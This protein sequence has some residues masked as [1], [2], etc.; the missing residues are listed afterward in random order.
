MRL[1]QGLIERRR[2]LRNLFFHLISANV[3]PELALLGLAGCQG[4]LSLPTI[5]PSRL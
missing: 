2:A 5:G 3:L 4:Q 1:H